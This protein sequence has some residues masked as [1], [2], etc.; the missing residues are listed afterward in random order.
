MPKG[1]VLADPNCTGC[2]LHETATNVCVPADGSPD[3]EIMFLGRNPG[4]DEDKGN[5]PFIGRAGQLLRNAIG[6]SDLDE[7]EVF[8]TNVVKCHTPGNR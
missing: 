7:S 3:V 8:L 5:R 6:A 2:P 1:G 4:E